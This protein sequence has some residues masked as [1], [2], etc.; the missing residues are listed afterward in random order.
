MDDKAVPVTGFGG[1]GLERRVIQSGRAITL[2]ELFT[3][4]LFTEFCCICNVTLLMDENGSIQRGYL[5]PVP[6]SLISQCETIQSDH[7]E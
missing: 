4:E 3:Y 7:D 1:T 2:M 6:Y 5:V